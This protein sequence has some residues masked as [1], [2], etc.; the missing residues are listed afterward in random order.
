MVNEPERGDIM[1]LTVALIALGAFYALAGV[2]TR[3]LY[4][5]A[6][7][8]EIDWFLHIALVLVWPFFV[9]LMAFFPGLLE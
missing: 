5:E 6:S 2:G 3:N 7:R 1:L 4:A 8:L 9:V